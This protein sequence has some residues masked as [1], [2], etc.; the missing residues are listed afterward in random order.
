VHGELGLIG[1][2]HA[3]PRFMELPVMRATEQHHSINI[4]SATIDPMI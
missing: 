4:G 2:L 3:V 1:K